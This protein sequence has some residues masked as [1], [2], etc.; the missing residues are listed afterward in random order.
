MRLAHARWAEEHHVLGALDKGEGSQF[1][2]LL[3]RRA[4]GK[5]EVIPLSG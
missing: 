2:D 1:L 3:P 4:A 5:G